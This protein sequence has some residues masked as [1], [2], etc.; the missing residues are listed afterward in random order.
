MRRDPLC[1]PCTVRAAYDIA[2]R[3][4]GDVELWE[5]A[6]REV[7][8]WLA[9]TLPDQ[10]MTPNLLHTNAYRIV[11]KIT[12]NRDP[13]RELK[14]ESNRIASA[15]VP[16][17]REKYGRMDH[18]GG[19]RFAAI[20]AICGN[21]IDF[22]VEGHEVNLGTIISQ[23]EECVKSGLTVDDT[24]RLIET[25]QRSRK[26]VYLLDN[27]GE[28]VFDKFFMEAIRERYPVKIYAAVKSGPVLNDATLEDAEEIKLGEVAEII[29]TGS[30]SIGLV[31][32]ECSREFMRR[33]L[34][35][36]LVI[37]KGQGYYES[38]TEIQD[39][40]GRPII[41]MLK[42]KCKVVARHLGVKAGDNVLKF[43]SP[44]WTEGR[45]PGG[46]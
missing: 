15:M 29:E 20:S 3:A 1:V 6:L 17:L 32:E 13:F 38:L 42:A 9:S 4:S 7:L 44:E 5:R 46:V 14:R 40:I 18:V 8:G 35:A 43:V 34:E 39:K 10:R 33:L 37:S 30:D 27:S 11:V 22:E 23:L 21:S 19:L 28:I 25:L 16:S 41:Y 2:V 31:P 12:G 26:I 24:A 45:A 36:D